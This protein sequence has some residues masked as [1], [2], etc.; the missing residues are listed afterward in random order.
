MRL[1]GRTDRQAYANMLK[2]HDNITQL[3]VLDLV[4]RMSFISD[5][6]IFPLQAVYIKAQGFIFI[7]KPELPLSP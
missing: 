5:I 6:S 3:T 7:L 2:T 1:D 4:L